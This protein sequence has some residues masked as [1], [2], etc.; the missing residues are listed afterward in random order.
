V[1]YVASYVREMRTSAGAPRVYLR[2]NAAPE[3]Y[4]PA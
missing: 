2:N 1:T 3:Y 4:N